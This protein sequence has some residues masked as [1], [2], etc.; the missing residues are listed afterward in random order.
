[1]YK[2]QSAISNKPGG[3]QQQAVAHSQKQGP[4]M[5]AKSSGYSN[6]GFD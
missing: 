1:M 6:R 2:T 3:G 5:G 4:S